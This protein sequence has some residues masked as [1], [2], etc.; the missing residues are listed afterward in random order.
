MIY[1]YTVVKDQGN[2]FRSCP[3][4]RVHFQNKSRIFYKSYIWTAPSESFCRR[5]IEP[6]LMGA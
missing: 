2:I 3:H 6:S 5:R 1:Q 4:A